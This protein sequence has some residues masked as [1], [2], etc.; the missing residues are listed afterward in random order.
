MMSRFCWVFP[1][2]RMLRRAL[3]SVLGI[4]IIL[5]SVF[6]AAALRAEHFPD[7]VIQAIAMSDHANPVDKPVQDRKVHVTCSF[8]I[9]CS[10]FTVPAQ[11]TFRLNSQSETIDRIDIPKLVTIIIAPPLPPPKFIILI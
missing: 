8:G 2:F 1:A 7:G 3:P 11:E 10:A 4:A 9:G 5:A 6:P